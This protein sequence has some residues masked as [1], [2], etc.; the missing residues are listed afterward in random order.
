M[1][2]IVKSGD[3]PCLL[4]T[5]FHEN[6]VCIRCRDGQQPEIFKLRISATAAIVRTAGAQEAVK[7]SMIPD[8]PKFRPLM[9]ATNLQVEELE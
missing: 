9:E 7:V 6:G 8:Y 1:R 4:S 2:F 5:D 3:V